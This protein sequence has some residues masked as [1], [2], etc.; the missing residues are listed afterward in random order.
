MESINILYQDEYYIAVEKPINLLVH[1]YKK[2]SNERD[3]LMKR[4]KAQTG[5][6]LYPIHRL[7]RPVSG[8][9]IFGL[10]GENVA[11][12]Q[13]KWSL[14]TTHKKYI[15]LVK[16]LLKEKGEFTFSLQKEDKS[17][18]EAITCYKPLQLFSETTLI[19]VEIKT[20]RRHQIRRHFSRRSHNIIGDRKHG[21][22]KVNN[23]YKDE[24]GLDRI[25]LHAQSL[26]FIHPYTNKTI[27]IECPLPDD[28][29]TC[30]SKLK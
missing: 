7:D 29:K 22:G 10:A 5:L 18:Q 17:K 27:K 19:E 8:I 11:E 24:I 25:F 16:G 14:E 30:L 23:F 13:K 28:L 1:P 15:A 21:R 12:L 2:E 26:E 6:Y 4:V 20:G 9:V 3:H